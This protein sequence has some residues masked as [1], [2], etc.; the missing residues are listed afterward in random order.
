MRVGEHGEAGAILARDVRVDAEIRDLL[1]AASGGTEAVARPPAAQRPGKG[2]LRQIHAGPLR[3]TWR[4]VQR[5]AP[6]SVIARPGDRHR[7]ARLLD[8]ARPASLER[9]PRAAARQVEAS[10]VLEEP[11]QRFDVGA[12][13]TQ[14]S[15]GGL[16][17]ER[18]PLQRRMKVRPRGGESR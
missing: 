7:G 1:G 13:R 8:R 2:C 15:F 4:N 11:E 18:P 16:G 6:P 9:H 14:S 12:L 5:T 17:D 3:I 10:A